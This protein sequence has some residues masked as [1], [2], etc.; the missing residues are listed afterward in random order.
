VHLNFLFFILRKFK[1]FKRNNLKYGKKAAIWISVVIYIALG[2]AVVT[3]VLTAGIP[4]IQKMKDQNTFV[5]TKDLLLALDRNIRDVALE[6]PGARRFLSPVEITR[7]NLYI[8]DENETILWDMKTKARMQEPNM[9]FE[10]GPLKS[11]LNETLVVGEYH[12]KVWLNYTDFINIT[13]KSETTGPFSGIFNIYVK[14]VGF[15]DKNLPIVE[16]EITT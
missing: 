9:V 7:G 1:Y 15:D 8:F 3:I 2:I 4:L 10:E 16:L 6:G 5:Q 13:P 14:H 12:L 11:L